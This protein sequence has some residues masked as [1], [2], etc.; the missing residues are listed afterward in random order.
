ME[1]ET[2]FYVSI[3]LIIFFSFLFL[4]YY[5]FFKRE[6]LYV[7]KKDVKTPHEGLV[8]ELPKHLATLRIDYI[9]KFKIYYTGGSTQYVE[10]FRRDRTKFL[11][12]M[13]NG[14]LILEFH[15]FPSTIN[16]LSTDTPNK[17]VIKSLSIIPFQRDVNLVIHQ[18]LRNIDI[19]VNHS[20]MH[21]ETLPYIPYIG[22]ANAII[23]PEGGSD[24]VYL[25][26][27]DVKV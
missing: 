2:I 9:F 4:I 27:F 21:M 11:L 17:M 26:K 15:R 18:D 16:D 10:L 23:L 22:N 6:V 25:K 3:S 5:F 12:D 1:L 19:M 13:S 7:K 14:S 24:Y 20:S 8:I